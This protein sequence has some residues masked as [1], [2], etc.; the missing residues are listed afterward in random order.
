MC[1][2]PH[3]LSGLQISTSICS[4]EG[5]GNRNRAVRCSWQS[6]ACRLSFVARTSVARWTTIV[7]SLCILY[8]AKLFKRFARVMRIIEDTM[9]QIANVYV[10]T[11]MIHPLKATKL[12]SQC[13]A[14]TKAH[15]VARGGGI[16]CP[17]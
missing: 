2:C 9:K 14:L 17:L 8:V 5:G 3:R 13:Y 12:D 4:G 11:T 16:G 6:R 7:S 10:E 1:A 15:V